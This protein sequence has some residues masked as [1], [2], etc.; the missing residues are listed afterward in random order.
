MR[1]YV[2][3]RDQIDAHMHVL[4]KLDAAARRIEGILEKNEEIEDPIAQAYECGLFQCIPFLRIIPDG[5]CD[6]LTLDDDIVHP[7]RL[8][9]RNPEQLLWELA[10]CFRL[11]PHPSEYHPWHEAVAA[12]YEKERRQAMSGTVIETDGFTAWVLAMEG[13]RGSA[14]HPSV[15]EQVR[16]EIA[17]CITER[18]MPEGDALA[19]MRKGHARHTTGNDSMIS[20]SVHWDH[21]H[22]RR[23]SAIAKI[24]VSSMQGYDGIRTR[25][26]ARFSSQCSLTFSVLKLSLP[27][28]PDATVLSLPGKSLDTIINDPRLHGWNITVRGV[29]RHERGSIKNQNGIP[30]KETV[31]VDLDTDRGDDHTRLCFMVP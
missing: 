15:I 8:D 26:D 2:G 3:T 11:P 27:G 6:A 25:A 9:H 31:Q 17:A 18:R 21:S 23:Y 30:I 12:R 7:I 28:I 24:D 10:Q 5:D 4:E 13:M 16:T 19:Y 1:P 22:D 20:A 29:M 14:P